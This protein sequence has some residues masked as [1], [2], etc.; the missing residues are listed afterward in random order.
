MNWRVVKALLIKQ[1]FVSSRNTFRAL[2]VVFWPIMDLLIWGFVS[3]YMLKVSH[4][5]PTVITFMIGA[6]ILWNVLMRAQQVV[7]VN[8]LE[9]L[10]SRNLLNLWASP[11]R[12]IE[13]MTA[14]YL[15]SLVQAVLVVVLMGLVAAGFY[16]FNVLSLGLSAG[17]LY[18]NLMITGWS[19]GLVIVG[20]VLRYGP[21]AEALAWAL[22]FIL[23]PVS[24]VFY[25]VSILPVWMQ[26]ISAFVPAAHVFEGMRQ[27]LDKGSLDPVHIWCAFGLNAVYMILACLLFNFLLEDARRK[28]FLAKYAA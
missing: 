9:E 8:F 22:P 2:D 21:P 4:A 5:V 16:S 10:W 14:L 27:I 20:L 26:Q 19:M 3:I 11:A 6:I 15:M 18:A 17:V 7:S 12:P 28:G 13:Y 24:A 23:Q 1:G 25:P